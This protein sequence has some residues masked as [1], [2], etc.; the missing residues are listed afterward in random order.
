MPKNVAGRPARPR[1]P[2]LDPNARPIWDVAEELAA[3][4]PGS[5]WRKVPTD[6]AKNLHHYL[7]GGP[8]EDAE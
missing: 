8:K 5:E 1:L 3:D 7:H 2:K 4:V 6:L